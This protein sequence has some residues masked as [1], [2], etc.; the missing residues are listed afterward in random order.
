MKCH[1]SLGSKPL[2]EWRSGSSRTYLENNDFIFVMC[3]D[4]KRE[5][6]L[7]LISVVLPFKA[8]GIES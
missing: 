3:M 6:F 8:A 5:R 1:P 7:G 4:V 2:S